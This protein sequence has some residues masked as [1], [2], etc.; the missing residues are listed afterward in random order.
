MS[1]KLSP[2]E[3][4]LNEKTIKTYSFLA[5]SVLL[6]YNITPQ[7]TNI[8]KYAKFKI[9]MYLGK[10]IAKKDKVSKISEL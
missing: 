9:Y 7:Y 2:A 10:I 6:F 8:L 4:D 3:G 5:M 1:E